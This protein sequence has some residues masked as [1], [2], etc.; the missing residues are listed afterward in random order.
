MQGEHEEDGPTEEE[1]ARCKIWTSQPQ[2]AFSALLLDEDQVQA[3][4]VEQNQSHQ[5]ER[6]DTQSRHR[7]V[8]VRN[9][10]QQRGEIKH[11]VA[12]AF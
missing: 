2:A 4:A 11:A 12:L 5:R 1:H 8:F 7:L 9:S 6:T 3:T 10:G